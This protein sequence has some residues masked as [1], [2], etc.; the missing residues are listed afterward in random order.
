MVVSNT[1]LA[2][3]NG[4]FDNLTNGQ[5]VMLSYGGTT[6]SFAANYFGGSGNDLVL[7]WANNRAFAWGNNADGQLGD[8]TTTQRQ[9]PVPVTATGVL[10]GKTVVA[11]AA[12]GYHS[13]VLC[14]D[15]TVAAYGLNGNGQ[16]G[17]NT[18]TERHVPVAMNTASAASA[19]FGKTVVA[20]AAGYR[21]SVAL[22]SDGTVATWGYNTDGQLGDN[23][24][25]GIQ[26]LVPVA[27]NT[28]SGVSALYSKT[29][30]AIA[31]GLA[32]SLAL[33]SDGT[34]AAW[35][36]NNYGQLGNNTSGSKVP[37]A[38]NTNSGVSAL[39]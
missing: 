35:D 22:C 5:P 18:K 25:S 36:R 32:H 34:V 4:T 8:D 11:A 39:Y 16:L 29:V 23:G 38:V 27:V 10:A 1:A 2:F 7:V 31:A 15:G 24:V 33:C 30:V 12:G 6:Y 20:I 37:V 13:L 14:S 21:H 3:I 28:A 19:L 26:S 9:L 17:D